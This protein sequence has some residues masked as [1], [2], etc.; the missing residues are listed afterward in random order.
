ME[1]VGHYHHMRLEG[2]SSRCGFVMHGNGQY[3]T[4]FNKLKVTL[5]MYQKPHSIKARYFGQNFAV[6]MTL[7]LMSSSVDARGVYLTHGWV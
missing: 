7:Q 4:M 1:P 3:K 6:N 5:Y 2:W